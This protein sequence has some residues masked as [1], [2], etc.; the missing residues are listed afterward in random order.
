MPVGC[1]WAQDARGRRAEGENSPS[2]VNL[3]AVK[4]SQPDQQTVPFSARQ[5]P[6]SILD[7]I[8]YVTDYLGDTSFM[9]LDFLNTP[10]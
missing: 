7:Y 8:L 5:L 2:S 10:F 6:I 3:R 4:G 1:R 9:Y